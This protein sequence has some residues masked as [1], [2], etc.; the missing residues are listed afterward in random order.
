MP[1]IVWELKF[2]LDITL[3]KLPTVIDSASQWVDDYLRHVQNDVAFFRAL[4]RR[5]LTDRRTPH[6]ERANEKKFP[7]KF[8]EGDV[9]M[10]RTVIQNN[11]AKG[12]VQKLVYQTRGPY[13]VVS[14]SSQDT[15]KCYKYGKLQGVIKRIRTEDIYL[16]PPAIYPC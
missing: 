3:A 15:Y 13:V 12:I 4:I 14:L 16:L 7:I 8:K 2:P 1:A 10:V 5:I 9:V 6:R 11:K